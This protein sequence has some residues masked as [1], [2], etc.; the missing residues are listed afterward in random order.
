[1]RPKT[2]AL[3]V[4]FILF[5]VILLQNS[6][7][8]PVELLFWQIEMPLF[9]LIIGTIL[10]GLTLGWL[11]HMAYQRGRRHGKPASATP[12]QDAAL[13]NKGNIDDTEAEGARET[14]GSD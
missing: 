8:T 2:I 13:A 10:L 6:E 3:L 5:A 9:V 7:T 1:M 12:P 11:T 14:H 4:V